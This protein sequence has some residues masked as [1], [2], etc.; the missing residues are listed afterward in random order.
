MMTSVNQHLKSSLLALELQGVFEHHVSLK[1]L[2]IVFLFNNK[3][4]VYSV[5]LLWHPICFHSVHSGLI[6]PSKEKKKDKKSK[7]LKKLGRSKSDH[8][9]P[10]QRATGLVGLLETM[11]VQLEA[12]I[13]LFHF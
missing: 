3:V 8:V 10:P 1:N 6:V 12:S 11:R 13:T 4:F 5:S 9:A 2:L 7:L